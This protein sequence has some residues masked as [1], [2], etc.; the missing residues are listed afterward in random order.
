MGN[1]TYEQFVAWC[2]HWGFSVEEGFKA[3]C[4]TANIVGQQ[5]GNCIDYSK[6]DHSEPF[7]KLVEKGKNDATL[8][9]VLYNE[10]ETQ[11]FN[12]LEKH[13]KEV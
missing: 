11:V 9:L 8:L 6:K 1:I 4:F 12:M 13:E 7:M 10:L 2:N 5:Y 3:M